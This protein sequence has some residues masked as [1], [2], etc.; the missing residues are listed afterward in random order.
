[1]IIYPINIQRLFSVARQQYLFNRNGLHFLTIISVLSI[2]RFV[3]TNAGIKVR[4]MPIY[5]GFVVW[6]FYVHYRDGYSRRI[7]YFLLDVCWFSFRA[8]A[9]KVCYISVLCLCC[10]VIIVCILL[11]SSALSFY[12]FWCCGCCSARRRRRWCWRL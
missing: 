5:F 7:L 3:I 10:H 6:P 4:I 9:P 1:M 8:F 2:I 12:S 11:V